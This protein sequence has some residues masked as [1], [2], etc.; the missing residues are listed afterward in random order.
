MSLSKNMKPFRFCN[1]CPA[2][3][4]NVKGNWS[5][6]RHGMLKVKYKS[7]SDGQTVPEPVRHETCKDKPRNALEALDKSEMHD[8]KE[9]VVNNEVRKASEAP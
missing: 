6:L 9:T 2:L 5:C 3:I 4:Q 7:I 1:E 8:I